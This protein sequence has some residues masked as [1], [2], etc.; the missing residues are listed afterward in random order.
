[1]SRQPKATETARPQ[2]PLAPSEMERAEAAK[3]VLDLLE[4]R[5]KSEDFVAMQRVFMPP[6]LKEPVS[7]T[8]EEFMEKMSAAIGHGL[9]DEYGELF[10]KIDVSRDGLIDWDKLTS[11]M[12]LELYEKDERAKTLVVPQWK[13]IKLLPAAHKE[14]IQ[15]IVFLKSSSRYLTVSKDGSLGIWEEDLKLQRVLRVA[16]DSVKLKNL[17]VT[18]M[19]TLANVNKIA[20]GFT[21]KEI[22]FFDLNSKQEFACQYR[23]QGL[24]S[25]PICMDY[26]SNPED[27]NEAVLM[28]GNV[29]GQV[30]ALCFTA[31]LIS[32]FERPASSTA[33]QETTVAITW[34]ELASGYHKCCYTLTHKAHN[35]D[36]VRQ[37]SY[38]PNLEAFVSCTIGKTNTM[39]LGWKEKEK[40]NFRT[41]SFNSSQGINSFDYHPGLN[42]IATAGMDHDVCLWNPYVLS[43]PAGVLKG[44]MASIMAVQFTVGRKQLFSFSKDKVLRIWD[45]QHQLCIQRISGIFPKTLEFCTV[46]YFDEA[47]GRLFATFNSQLTLLEMKQETGRVTSHANPITFVLYNSTFKQVISSDSGSTV[48]FWMIDTGQKIKQFTGCHGKAEI[49]AMALNYSETRLFT[50]STD[51]TVK[52]WDFNG[53]CH[54][55]LNAGRNKEVDISQILLLKRTI[56][57]IGWERIITVF[58]TNTLTRC[59][60]QPLEWK[61]GVQ[62]HDDILCAA[63]LP[64]HTLATEGSYDGEIIIWNN[65]TENASRKLHPD[66]KRALKSKSDSQLPQQQDSTT[67]CHSHSPPGR[68]VASALNPNSFDSECNYAVTRLVFL[69]TRKNISSAGAANLVSCGASGFVRFW[70]IFRNHLQAEFAAHSETGSIVMTVDKSEQY[71]ISGDFSGW[72]KVWNIQEY[73]LCFNESVITQCPPLVK[74]FQPHEDCVTHLETCVHSGQLLILSA[75]TDCSIAVTDIYGTAVGIFGQEEHWQI[76]HSP[77]PLTLPEQVAEDED[78]QTNKYTYA[79]CLIMDTERAF[80]TM[81]TER[82]FLT[83]DTERAFLTMDTFENSIIDVLKKNLGVFDCLGFTFQAESLQISLGTFSSLYIEGLDDVDEVDLPDFVQNPHKYFR[84]NADK[85]PSSGLPPPT[86]Y[87]AVKAAFDEKTLFPKEILDREQKA[88]QLYEQ[89]FNDGKLRKTKRQS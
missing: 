36:W 9:K 1:C 8:R 62:H 33:D 22:C 19:V 70:N 45:T 71:L 76:K 75:S 21:S 2:H 7:M 6:D 42:L 10:D 48:T 50:G 81:D 41:T 39:V 52:I 40:A 65:N 86:F 47:H 35:A 28:F 30:S 27:G 66:V 4:N 58:R 37:V 12:L 79:Q 23:L 78:K 73:C 53:H 54:H 59:L 82:A 11:F 5:L 55:K 61:G 24:Q 18:S 67:R 77:P 13:D 38:C 44:H 51:G 83:M 87:G 3:D 20:V 15:K 49:T 43:K 31:A 46:L 14:P 84:E 57:V 80:L 17:W 64:P 26:W 63:F 68:R 60:V 88:R 25:T 89:M 32:L 29:T 85:N 56:L 16:T 69:E 72:V 34:R 74:S